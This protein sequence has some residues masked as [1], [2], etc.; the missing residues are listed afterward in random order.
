MTNRERRERGIDKQRAERERGIDKQ[1]AERDR[2][3]QTFKKA[4]MEAGKLA[5]WQASRLAGKWAG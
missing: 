4:G 1:R 2:E 3:R 5:S